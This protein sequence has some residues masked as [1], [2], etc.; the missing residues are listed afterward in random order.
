[1]FLQPPMQEKLFSRLLKAGIEIYIYL[2]EMLHAK[3]LSV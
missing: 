2:G 3:T 1:M